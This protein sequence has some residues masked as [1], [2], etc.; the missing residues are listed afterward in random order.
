MDNVIAQNVESSIEEQVDSYKK[1]NI[2][3]LF[4]YAKKNCTKC[5]GRGYRT[6]V[7]HVGGKEPW[8]KDHYDI[9]PCVVK[10]KNFKELVEKVNQFFDEEKKRDIQKKLTETV[11]EK[12]CQ[13]KAELEVANCVEEAIS[14]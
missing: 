4:K 12:E 10:N 8:V 9:C 1:M 7:K 3:D 6:M 5:Y 2:T 11:G 13:E 14:Q